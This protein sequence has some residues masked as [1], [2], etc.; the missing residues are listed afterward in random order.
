M[1]VYSLLDLNRHFT[2]G[3]LALIVVLVVLLLVLRM[4]ARDHARQGWL[5]LVMD[6]LGHGER[7]QHPFLSSDQYPKPFGVGRQDYYFRYNL[8][9]QLQLV[10]ESLIGWMAWD[11]MRGVDLLCSREDVDE[12]RI[13]LIGSVAG[14][15]DP[16][17]VAAALDPRI[18]AVAPFNFGGPQPDYPI[19]RDAKIT[20]IY[21]GTSEIQD[22]VIA[23]AIL[24]E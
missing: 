5:V 16:A 2:A 22:V 23:R 8:G 18:A 20:Q 1:N 6:L 19:P 13:V 24:G 10:G 4:I 21:E 9:L 3:I 15:G 11:L 7:R 12:D 14:G 17:A